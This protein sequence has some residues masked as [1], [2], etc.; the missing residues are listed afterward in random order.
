MNFVQ[1][2]QYTN[3]IQKSCQ[4]THTHTHTHTHAGY[5]QTID[6]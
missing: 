6:T 2:T 5:G 1:S 4:N 3:I